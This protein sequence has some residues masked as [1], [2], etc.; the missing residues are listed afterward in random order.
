MR[1]LVQVG[2][3]E[4]PMDAKGGSQ[5]LPKEKSISLEGWGGVACG[6]EELFSDFSEVDF[7]TGFR[8]C[9]HAEGDVF[10]H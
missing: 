5:S 9:E 6:A 10:S 2:A 7:G 4:Y 8:K 1:S 3:D